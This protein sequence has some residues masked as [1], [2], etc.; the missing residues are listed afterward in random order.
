MKVA[1]DLGYQEQRVTPAPHWH[2]L[3]VRSGAERKAALALHYRG[4]V[5]YAPVY[6]EVRRYSDRMK[7]VYAAIFPGY[8]FCRFRPTWKVSVLSSPAVEYIVGGTGVHVTIDESEIEAI[9]RCIAAGGRAVPYLRA[10]QRVRI[11]HGSLTGI[12]G[13]FL[14]SGGAGRLVLSVDL[15]QRSIAVEIDSDHVRPL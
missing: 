8:I 9:R 7:T 12:E 10:G 14:R 4:F 11:E 5:S 13:I 3:K 6:Q 2:A 1:L 15:L